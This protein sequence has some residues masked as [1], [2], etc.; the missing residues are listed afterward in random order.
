MNKKPSVFTKIINEELPANIHYQDDEFIVIDDISPAAPIHVMIIPKHPYET[1]EEVSEDNIEFYGKMIALARKMAKKLGI[2]KN[3]KLF[4]N[5]GKKVQ[6]V[7]H[8]HL[9]LTGGWEEEKDRKTIRN[10][11]NDKLIKHPAK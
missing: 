10:E 11:I 8:I 6:Y 5:V 3:Y 9:H 4:M 1:L 7:H 2:S